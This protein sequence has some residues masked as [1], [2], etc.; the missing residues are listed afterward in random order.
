MVKRWRYCVASYL[1]VRAQYYR[2]RAVL[3]PDLAAK[4]VRAARDDA[5]CARFI[6]F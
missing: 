2:P 4:P 3:C 5:G 6:G 1:R